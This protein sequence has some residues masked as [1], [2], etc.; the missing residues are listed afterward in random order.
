MPVADI[1]EGRDLIYGVLKTAWA[2][3]MSPPP[4]IYQDQNAEK[5]LAG[6]PYAEAEIQHQDG[7]NAAIGDS[8]KKRV[9]SV[10]RLTVSIYTVPGDGLTVQDALVKIV[11]NAFESK[12]N[13]GGPEKIIIRKVRVVEDGNTGNAFRVRVIVDY[14]YDRIQGM[15]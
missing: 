4:L 7:F 5:P 13:V 2:A 9:R 14:E 8:G 12:R 6:A 1:A 10:A 3:Q 11:Q 15:S